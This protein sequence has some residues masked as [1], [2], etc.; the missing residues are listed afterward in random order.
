VDYV[1]REQPL[2]VAV[3]GLAA[4]AALAAAF[5]ATK[6]EQDTIGEIGSKVVEA[7]QDAGG[8]IKDTAAKAS[9]RLKDGLDDPSKLKESVSGIVDD[10]SRAFG[11]E[12]DRSSA[13]GG[14]APRS[15]TETT[16]QVR[17]GVS[18]ARNETSSGSPT[19]KPNT[20]APKATPFDRR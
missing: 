13:A 4:G 16:A 1:L 9:E 18:T 17:S 5:P 3:A 15:P 2:A 8:Q 12:T 6:L 14:N 19:G 10:V 11:K 7:T 20:V